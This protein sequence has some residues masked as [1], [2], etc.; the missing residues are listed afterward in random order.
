V[1]P[2]RT[3]AQVGLVKAPRPRTVTKVETNRHRRLTPHEG[4]P[5]VAKIAVGRLIAE[6]NDNTSNFRSLTL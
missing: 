6:V 2:A 1:I 5:F 3:H 4:D